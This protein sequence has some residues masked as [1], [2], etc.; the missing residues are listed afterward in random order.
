MSDE[1]LERFHGALV[2]A[3]RRRDPRELQRPFTV[4]E[5]Y[6][7]LVPYRAYRDLLGVEMNGDYEH[8]LLRLL[9]GEGDFL[10]ME[11]EHAVREIRE[12]LASVNPNTGLYRAF[13]AVDVRLN[14]SLVEH[15][16]VSDAPDDVPPEDAGTGAAVP[17]EP[18]AGAPPESPVTPAPQATRPETTEDPMTRSSSSP[19]V[20]P[21]CREGL[22]RRDNL[23][24]CPF[25]GTDVRL[26]P[27]PSC[28]DAMEPDWRFCIACGAAASRD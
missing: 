17:M 19:D 10:Q 26:V 7:D 8:A 11:S 4:A 12:E 25:C 28:G 24:F 15:A 6:H 16:E 1:V 3:L 23:T 27:C 22:P 20:C 9:A 18:A 2:D 5:I 21:W 14:P 13:A